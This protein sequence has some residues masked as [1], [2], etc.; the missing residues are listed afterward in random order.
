VAQVVDHIND[1]LP[2]IA[3]QKAQVA[4]ATAAV[5]LAKGQYWPSVDLTSTRQ[6][7]LVPSTQPFGAATYREDTLTQVQLSMP[8]YSGGAT[9]AGV[10]AAVSQLSAAQNTLDEVRL[11]AREKAVLA[12]E[13][14]RNA[15]DRAAQGLAQSRVGEQVVEGYRQQFRLARRQLLD[16]LNIQAESFG[17][18][19]AAMTAIYDEQVARV[20]LLAVMGDLAKRF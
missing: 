7:N 13:D 5:N 15:K 4:A 10:N 2:N 19:S 12:Y 6:M 3:Q 20:R 8:L 18:Q 14:W 17:Y 9:A 1:D 11:L 16:L